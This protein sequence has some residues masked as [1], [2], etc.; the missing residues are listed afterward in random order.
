MGKPLA[1]INGVTMIRRVY[2][3]VEKSGRFATI[4]VATDDTR[5][6]SE[7]KSFGGTAFMTSTQH[8]SGSERLWEVMEKNNFDAA[9]NIQGDEPIVSE[10]LIANLYDHLETGSYEVVTP[11]YYST[12]YDDYLSKHVVKV[13]VDEQSRA[14]YFSRSPIPYV[15]PGE[16]SGFY[17][18]IG[19]YGYLRGALERFINLSPSSLELSEKLEQLRFLENG[20]RIKVI[21][22][23]FNS[24]G[25]DVPED[26]ARVEAILAEETV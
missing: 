10:E 15:E 2:R 12:G 17:Q 13:V 25:V 20:I 24:I 23:P 7:V 9:V 3:Q 22:S 8:R 19:M 14:L 18:H 11:I 6:E 21:V 26:I 5:I 4:I 1:L 16:F